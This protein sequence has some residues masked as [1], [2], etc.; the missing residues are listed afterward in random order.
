M[1]DQFLQQALLDEQRIQ[2]PALGERGAAAGTW[3]QRHMRTNQRRACLRLRRPA[4][5]THATEA[6]GAMPARK[7]RHNLSHAP[8]D[9]YAVGQIYLPR[10]E[11][12]RHKSR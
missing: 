2:L 8:A 4:C 11:A 3:L 9:D 6:E 1:P 7:L 10:N 12:L 5:S